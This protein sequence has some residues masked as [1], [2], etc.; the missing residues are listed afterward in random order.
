MR[1]AQHNNEVA[2]EMRER[3]SRFENWNEAR[4]ALTHQRAHLLTE[5]KQLDVEGDAQ[6]YG[7]RR[8]VDY[9]QKVHMWHL[10]EVV[11]DR[12]V[13]HEESSHFDGRY[14]RSDKVVPTLHDG[15]PDL[16]HLNSARDKRLFTMEFEQWPRVTRFKLWKTSFRSEVVTGSAHPRPVTGWLLEIDRATSTQDLVEAGSSRVP[17]GTLGSQLQKRPCEDHEL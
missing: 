3:E 1:A 11:R 9:E 13:V 10:E 14:E 7:I 17:F 12:D 8:Q 16:H 5:H 4:I 2:V 6:R 15:S